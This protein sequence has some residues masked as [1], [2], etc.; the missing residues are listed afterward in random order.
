ATPSPPAETVVWIEQAMASLTCTA[1]AEGGE[2]TSLRLPVLQN[3]GDT[4]A[5]RAYF[6]AAPRDARHARYRH[7]A[8]LSGIA[9]WAGRINDQELRGDVLANILGTAQQAAADDRDPLLFRQIQ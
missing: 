7:L 3:P 9:W 1:L 2:L 5:L 8:T 4:N 6:Q